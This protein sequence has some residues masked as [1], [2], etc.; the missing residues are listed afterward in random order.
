[1]DDL[2]VFVMDEIADLQQ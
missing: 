1:M 2:A